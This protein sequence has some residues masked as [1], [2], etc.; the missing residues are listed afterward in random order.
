VFAGLVV[1]DQWGLA[2]LPS[3]GQL[4]V[5]TLVLGVALPVVMAVSLRRRSAFATVFPPAAA[6]V[7]GWRAWA[8][9]GV[10]TALMAAGL[11]AGASAAGELSEEISLRAVGRQH[12]AA[13][14]AV[15]LALAAVQQAAL[16]LFVLPVCIE[17]AGGVIAGAA[18]AAV[19]FGALHLPNP[20]MT[21]LTLAAGAVWFAV[22]LRGGRLG[23][24][25]ASHLVLG[26]LAR[27]A[28]PQHVHLCMRVGA[29]AAPLSADYRLIRDGGDWELYRRLSSREFFEACGRDDDA[30]VLA[31][32]RELLGR[33]PKPEHREQWRRDMPF[34]T[35]EDVVR[36]FLTTEEYLGRKAGRW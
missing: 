2:R 4:A 20:P 17:A 5:R 34:R 36:E 12:P 25:I 10:A 19:L 11:L 9:A 31:L 30:F 15:K 14:L 32:Y 8:E 22:F 7:P 28:L 3:A 23:P 1:L 16:Q 27:L 26:T 29:D 13:W 6:T 33:G 18:M 21:A 24:L 35:R